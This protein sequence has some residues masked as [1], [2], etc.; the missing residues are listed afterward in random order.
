MKFFLG[1][2]DMYAVGVSGFRNLLI[3]FSFFNFFNF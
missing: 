3:F 1:D 2:F